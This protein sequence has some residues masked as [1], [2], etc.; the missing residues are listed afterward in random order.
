MLISPKLPWYA[1][2]SERPKGPLSIFCE[3][4]PGD[5]ARRVTVSSWFALDADGVHL[6]SLFSDYWANISFGV[7]LKRDL[8]AEASKIALNL[9][10]AVDDMHNVALLHHRMAW[11]HQQSVSGVLDALVAAKYLALDIELFHVELRSALDH[12]A[13]CISA[14]TSK[15]GQVPSSFRALQGWVRESRAKDLLGKDLVDLVSGA[16]WFPDARGLRDAM[17]HRGG[18]TEVFP[19]NELILF[20]VYDSAWKDLVSDKLIMH[21]ENVVNF[22]IYSAIIFTELL[23]FLEHLTLAL[24]ERCP[25]PGPKGDLRTRTYNLGFPS[26]LFGLSAYADAARGIIST[27]S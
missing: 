19:H 20:Q 9:G 14:V 8:P 10:H 3:D 26:Y 16:S 15:P 1:H 6:Q 4:L 18:R 17:V 2:M 24:A 27:Y 12:C 13:M 23:L 5:V 25:A 11:T 21:S 7:R 22:H